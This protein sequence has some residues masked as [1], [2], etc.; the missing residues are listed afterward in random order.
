MT[1]FPRGGRQR[2]LVN[3]LVAVTV[4]AGLGT[5]LIGATLLQHSA[6][7]DALDDASRRNAALASQY[8]VRL[9]NQIDNLVDVLHLVATRPELA[10]L[11]RSADAELR[12]VLR[13]TRTIDELVVYDASG[14]PVAAAASRFL[15]D[16]A[17]H[18][19]DAELVD[20]VA[21]VDVVR[22]A[23]GAG[24]TLELAV[25]IE[26]PPGQVVGV[27]LARA[28]LAA[29][30]EPLELVV[31]AE[32]PVPFLVDERGV[33]I[34]HRDRSRVGEV[35][36]PAAFLDDDGTTVDRR[37]GPY[38]V[39]GAPSAHLGASVVVEQAVADARAAVDDD[40]R[41]HIVILLV[42]MLAVVAAVVVTGEVLLRPLHRLTAAV[43]RIGRGERGVRAGT[44]GRAEIG[45]LANEI[46]R[47]A[48][49]LD[50]RE[51]QVEE[52]RA[53]SLLVGPLSD[54]EDVAQRIAHG[55]AALVAADGCVV[56]A[57][58]EHGGTT[59][60][61]ATGPPEEV[62]DAI[63][64]SLT[65][66]GPHRATLPGG[67]HIVA[68][69]LVS[70]DEAALGAVAAHRLDEPFSDDD[71]ALLDAFGSFASTALDNARRLQLQHA[72]VEQLQAAI[73]QRRD[74]I[75]TI[76]HEF[77]TPLTC[78]EGFSS[79]LLDGWDRYG[80][81]ERRDF[82]ARI[83]HHSD[84][85]NEL[86]GR[87]LDFT[88]TE[89]GGMFATLGTVALLPTTTQT[90]EVL[91]PLLAGRPV[92]LAVPDV[93]VFAD[94]VLLRRTLSNLL[95]NAIKYSSP[96]SPICVRA[97]VEGPHVR[98]EVVDEGV[99]LTPDEAARAF[100][101]FWRGGGTTTRARGTGLGLAL[102]AE[103]LRAMGTACEVTSEPGRGSTFSFTLPRAGQDGTRERLPAAAAPRRSAT[104]DDGIS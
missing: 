76:T 31:S 20:A 12:V 48:T 58:D 18:V 8:A 92:E 51:E 90:I 35:E 84:D 49:Q 23:E 94:P 17:D 75:G 86:V 98:V 1:R 13:V 91:T 41:S 66:T 81:D 47:M 39:A 82:V 40:L 55:A 37:D 102:V 95:S 11:D 101:P 28:P 33:V 24:S 96:Q 93:A 19:A 72:L 6:S 100:E 85:L 45:V 99:G 67:R 63:L 3:R 7:A 32:E 73:D 29:V 15:A 25:A 30:S 46:D 61:A 56:V 70:T 5:G 16:P 69:A 59:V 42:S 103:Y 43:G 14:V 88:V 26:D 62:R 22:L 34:V 78:I 36:D 97:T 52:L 53:L 77:R 104:D 38:V 54:R 57:I 64:A 60:D 2:R 44:T 79:T 10:A 71:V 74:L 9:D 87:F 65:G 83:G 27:L 4:V 50:R 80:D 21:D 89:R 68:V